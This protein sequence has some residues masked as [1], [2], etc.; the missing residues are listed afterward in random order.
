MLRTM[1]DAPEF[2]RLRAQLVAQV[3]PPLVVSATGKQYYF[4]EDS[5]AYCEIDIQ[6]DD[7]FAIVVVRAGS[8]PT[9]DFITRVWHRY[10]DEVWVI[11]TVDAT[12]QVIPKAGQT[13]RFGMGDTVRSRRLPEVAITVASVFAR[14]N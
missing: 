14:A 7:A 1:A 8:A 4:S 11:D 13:E 2:A 9:E 12:I 5:A 10:A 3:K 6:R